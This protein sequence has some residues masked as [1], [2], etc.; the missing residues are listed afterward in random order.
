MIRPHKLEFDHTRTASLQ[1]T[2]LPTKKLEPR[3]FL[4]L[5]NV[6]HR[7][8]ENFTHKAG[9]LHTL[10]QK[11]TPEHFTLSEEQTQ[12]FRKKKPKFFSLRQPWHLLNSDCLLRRH[13]YIS[14]RTRLHP[15]S[16]NPGRRKPNNPVLLSITRYIGTQPLCP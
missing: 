6:Y 5:C 11:N 2:L 14:V 3:P 15:P 4:G 13:R 1:H 12:A 9:S 10:L 8:A 7:F 16:N